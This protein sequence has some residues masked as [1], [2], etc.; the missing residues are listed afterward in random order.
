MQIIINYESKWGNSFLSEPD[1]SGN[2]TYV[3]SLTNI[4]K[5]KIYQEKNITLNTVYGVLYRLLGARKPLKNIIEEDNSVIKDLIKKNKINFNVYKVIKTDEL[6]YIRNNSL[7]TDQNNF[8]G[9]PDESILKF[10]NIEKA[11]TPLFY[12]REELLNY[13]LFDEFKQKENF[14]ISIIKISDILLSFDKNKSFKIN[15]EEYD[16]VNEVFYNIFKKNIHKNANLGFLAINKSINSFFKNK[17]NKPKELTANIT[18]AGISLN[19]NSYTLKDFMK[20]FAN[21]KIVYGNPYQTDFWVKKNNSDKNEKFNKK[22]TKESGVL[23]IDI[24]CDFQIAEEIKILLNNAGVSSFYL[25]K[26]GLAYVDE[27]II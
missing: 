18:F 7:N 10:E 4:N 6:V 11:L 17:K 24:D 23:K 3:A 20:K 16:K 21:P 2:R 25:G 13:I 5:N 14:P 27:I 12:N 9:I 15:E 19:G 8:S 26:K 1:N 22:M